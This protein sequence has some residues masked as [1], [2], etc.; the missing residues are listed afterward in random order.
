L[1]GAANRVVFL[2]AALLAS[3]AGPAAVAGELPES[4]TLDPTSG[5]PDAAVMAQGEGFDRTPCGVNL[6]FDSAEGPLL[7]FAG[8]EGGAFST[9]VN[10]PKNAA[11]GGH[12]ILAVGLLTS[13]EFCDGPSGEEARA[14][15]TVSA[16]GEGGIDYNIYLRTRVIPQNCGVDEDFLQEIQSST[17]PIH[18]I[19]QLQQ[20]PQMM[21]EPASARM[22]AG[23]RGVAT[24][25]DLEILEELGITLLQY[26]N[27]VSGPGTSY[28]A[29]IS[30]DVMPDDPRFEE[31]VRC[32]LPFELE[33]KVEPG[34]EAGTDAQPV[35]VQFFGDVDEQEIREL[36][37]T[38]MLDAEMYAPGLWQTIAS[39]EQILTLAADDAVQ[40][41]ES[42]P[43][44]FLPTVDEVRDAS[45]VDGLQDLDNMSGV[46]GGL[47]GAG[48]QVAIMDSGVDVDH[49]DFAGRF[50][51]A[52]DDGGDH[53]S[54][55]AGIAVGDGG[56]SDQ[57]NDDGI[58]NG[59]TPFQWRGMAPEAG[60][61][62]FGGA[63]GNAA[64]YDTAINTDG[65]DVSNHSYVL[66]VQNQYNATVSSVDSIVRGDSPGIPARPVVWA[67]ANNA[68]V[69]PRDCDDD[70][71]SDGN[72]PQYPGG[73]PTAF[74][75]GYFSLL[76]PC[77]NCIGVAS[78]DKDL[79]HSFF[80][81]MGPT[82]DGRLKPELSTIGRGVFAVGANTD[83]DGM[84]VTGNGY[85]FKSGTSMA[86]PAVTGIVALMLQQYASTFGVNLDTTP[87]LP[88]TVKAL[89][90]QSADD[91]ADT[92]PTINF[93]TGLPVTY[94]AGPDWATGYGLV[95]APAAVQIIADQGF[96]EDQVSLFDVTD[97]WSV[98][99]L[100]GQ[101]EV[102][103]TLAWDDIAGT[104]N[105]NDA[106]A[107]LVNDLDLVLIEPGGTMH[108]PLVLPLLMPRDCDGNAANG[109]QVGTCI[110]QDPA[111]QNYFGPAA[112]GT[113]RRNNVEQVVVE[114]PDGLMAGNWTARVSVLNPDGTT[115]RL[116]L[117]GTQSYSLVVQLP[118]RA[119]VAVCPAAPVV[120]E[121]G[122]DCCVT[123]T[124]A[125]LAEDFFDPNGDADI[126]TI[127]ITEVDG[128]AVACESSV[129]I[130]DTGD[131]TVAV[132]VTDLAGESDSCDAT[133]TVVDITP[134]SITCPDD[135]TLECPADTTPAAT[136]M[137]TATDNCDVPTI[138]FD[139]ESEPGC[140]ATE[141]IA[142]TW[143]A[144]DDSDL[145]SQCE[146]I[147][148][149]VD[150]TP[151]EVTCEV[152]QNRLWPP[153][154]RLIDVG[155][156]FDATDSCDSEMPSFEVAV[157]SDEHPAR[158]PGAGGA[159]HCPDA[160]ILDD[161][162][163]WLRSERAG[164]GDGRVYAITVSATDAC[165]NVGMCSRS[166]TVPHSM[167]Q[168]MG[169]I[170]S[171]QIFDPTEC[172][173]ATAARKAGHN[174]KPN[175]RSGR[176]K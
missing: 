56:R 90:V 123:V 174:F 21:E 48:V 13:G 103:V 87:P 20:L 106:A 28:L 59:G 10:I 142:R 37:S 7:G 91:L 73:C 70:G 36:F 171:G 45:S 50:V 116:P 14:T 40:W 157:T 176:V 151:P 52:G 51:R 109:V 127:C 75:A 76:S 124:A 6:H 24:Q 72:F 83:R 143:T 126:D 101:T 89:L 152:A 34:L 54:H 92:D 85:R 130:C 26:L 80:S 162:S 168:G 58:P 137:A 108:R 97:D 78:L 146:Q 18:G 96:L 154:H 60:I 2:L 95:N 47:S 115:A 9:T 66:Q 41:L 57:T 165:G 86:A 62:A 100:P 135:V 140:G 44:P 153:N 120:K 148:E 117:G 156:S 11:P 43:L 155:L 175:R 68:S 141:T 71:V 163:V 32:L 150:T 27:G 64:T 82:S 15:F 158:A 172:R 84:A 149:V 144:T 30:P 29:S 160:L 164:P 118:N 39:P 122:E 113:D 107:Q 110:G 35:L 169:A 42:G 49:D 74:Q 159:M 98:S 129:E 138:D 79:V 19:V 33:D 3:V 53:G 128:M 88:S 5:P 136:G 119:P 102:R 145:S 147:I 161:Q 139:D 114:D 131:H 166:I 105:S 134:P 99:V 112:E 25:S 16:T 93:D 170:D 133:V 22:S 12:T 63:G 173:D 104:P 65:A 23:L 111:G 55:V 31:L 4:L 38:L 46:Y 1:F 8:L 17:S 81:S 167:G 121:A 125:E 94:G 69:G 61:A 67:A 132:T 77:K